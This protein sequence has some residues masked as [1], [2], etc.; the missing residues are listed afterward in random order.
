MLGLYVP[1]QAKWRA[2]F[3][4]ELLRFPTATHDDQV[5]ALSLIGQL[6]DHMMV[7]LKPEP[8]KKPK[9][10]DWFSEDDDDQE[11]SWKVA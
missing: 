7:P 6:L 2:D 8:E 3:E 5:D 10:R 9:K 11:A 4:S 1:A